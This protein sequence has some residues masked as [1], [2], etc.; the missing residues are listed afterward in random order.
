MRISLCCLRLSPPS[1]VLGA[2]LQLT[3]RGDLFVYMTQD[4]M[5]LD[6]DKKQQS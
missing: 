1:P 4:V 2:G 3:S 6:I 5:G